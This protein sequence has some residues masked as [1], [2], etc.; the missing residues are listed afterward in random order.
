MSA[1]SQATPLPETGEAAATDAIHE[2]VDEL[3][4]PGL[5]REV[6]LMVDGRR[7]SYYRRVCGGE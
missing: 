5:V 4:A 1:Q 6:R 2:A 7:I 3:V